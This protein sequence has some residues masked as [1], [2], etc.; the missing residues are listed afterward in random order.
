MCMQCVTVAATSVGAAGGLRAWVA[1]RR[2][3]WVTPQ[4]LRILTA[5]LLTLAVLA[6]GIRP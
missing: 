2:P 6:A 3:S 1:A 5:V 4:R